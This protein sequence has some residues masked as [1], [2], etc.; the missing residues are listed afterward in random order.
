MKNE[1]AHGRFGLHHHPIGEADPDLLR[2]E[3]P[4]QR[5]LV[6]EIRTRRVTEAEPFAA[7][8]RGEA[9]LPGTEMRPWYRDFTSQIKS[10]F[11]KPTEPIGQHLPTGYPKVHR[12]RLQLFS[13]G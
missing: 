13:R 4:P 9:V 5:S 11:E 6:I 2:F 12:W 1:S 3:Q 7:V 10:V 8:P